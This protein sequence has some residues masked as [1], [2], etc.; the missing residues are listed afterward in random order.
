MATHWIHWWWSEARVHPGLARERPKQASPSSCQSSPWSHHNKKIK[1][2][3]SWTREHCPKLQPAWAWCLSQAGWL[4][5]NKISSLK[6]LT[7][8]IHVVND[9]MDDDRS[10]NKTSGKDTCTIIN[11]LIYDSHS[12]SIITYIWFSLLTR[13]L[14]PGNWNLGPG[15]WDLGPRTWDLGPGIWDLTANGWLMDD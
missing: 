15:T 5:V 2:I 4:C 1:K 3:Y 6:T 10:V 13:D 11:C 7:H 8:A 14:G 9:I 12:D